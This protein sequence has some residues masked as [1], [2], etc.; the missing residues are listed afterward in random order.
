MPHVSEAPADDDRASDHTEY[1]DLGLADESPMPDLPGFES[2]VRHYQAAALEVG[3]AILR[4]LAVSLDLD[5]GFFAATMDHPGC[6]LRFLHY[7]P[8]EPD[9]DGTLPVPTTP[10]T[11]YGAHHPAGHGRRRPGSK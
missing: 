11:D 6:K 4:A 2:A 9:P 10:H 3:A 1:L 8:V 5:P 7:P